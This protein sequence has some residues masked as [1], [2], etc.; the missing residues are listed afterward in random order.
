M[1]TF[2]NYKLA[3]GLVVLMYSMVIQG[4]GAN[5]LHSLH[6]AL[7]KAA[8]SM[9]AAADTNHQLYEGGVYGPVGNEAAIKVRQKAATVIHDANEKLILALTLAKS[10]TTAT[11]E[12]G[13]LAVLA[14][15]SQ[16]VAG[17]HV[18]NQTVD[19]ILQSVA[20]VIN[21]AVVLI[22]AFKSADLRFVLP[23][24]QDWKL[25]EVAA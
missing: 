21:E 1:R 20:A 17:L 3:L 15:L 4:C 16:A 12:Q 11:F 25:A 9:K 23:A 13:K 10:L 24:I 19:L 18:G 6:T 22:Q 7:N 14:A 5:D 2:R 8:R